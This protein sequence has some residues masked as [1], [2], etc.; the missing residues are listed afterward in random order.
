MLTP[1]LLYKYYYNDKISHK[2][3]TAG[4]GSYSLVQNFDR[5]SLIKSQ[6]WR[7]TYLFSGLTSTKTI[8]TSYFDKADKKTRIQ[9]FLIIK[10]NVPT[11]LSD[12]LNS[13]IPEIKI[14]E[15]KDGWNLKI[16]YSGAKISKQIL[17]K[18]FL[19]WVV[20]AMSLKNKHDLN[21]LQTK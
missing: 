4:L 1:N 14:I 9:D 7:N 17:V 3:T 18:N 21:L 5:I 2:T 16:R 10:I 19:S 8:T 13:H 11:I 15:L 20:T 6:M 12:E